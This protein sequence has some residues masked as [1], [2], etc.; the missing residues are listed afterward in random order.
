MKDDVKLMAEVFKVL[1]D[2]TR[3]RI[4]RMLAS[5]PGST[6]CVADLADRLGMTQ[7]AVSQHIKALKQVGLLEP[8]KQ[9]FRVYYY[10]DTDI[11]SSYKEKIDE[12][13]ELAFTKCSRIGN[14]NG[15][16]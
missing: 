4:I 10:I 14:C 7:P 3:L 8:D 15:H 12:M 2:T 6:L 13:F 9:G 1:G 11:L 5:N 16:G